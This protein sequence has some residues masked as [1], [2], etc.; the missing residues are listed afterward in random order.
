MV[1]IILKKRN[2]HALSEEEIQFAVNGF[3][4][5]SIP[6]YQMS[7]FLMAIYFQK[8]DDVE[9]AYLT[10]AMLRSGE[11]MDLSGIAGHVIDK[12]STGGVGDKTS[13][14]LAPLVAATGVPI[15][16]MSGRGLGHTGGT[17]DKLEAISGFNIDLE[18]SNF[19]KQVQDI[20][21][22]MCGQ[23]PNLVPADK[24]IYALRDVT[25]TVDNVSLIASSIM[26][27]KLAS[28]AEGIVIDIK[29]G[30]GAFMK[31][32]EDGVELARI[33]K[34]IA[35]HM[36]K[37]FTAI[38]TSMQQPLGNAIG[39][40][41]EVKEAIAT[42]RG[43]GPSDLLDVCLTLG[44]EMM[45]LS[46]VVDN[47]D[48]AKQ[49][50]SEKINSGAAFSKFKEWIA[51]QGGDVAQVEDMRLLPSCKFT[52]AY[53]AKSS[54]YIHH[55][56]ASNLGLASMKLGAGREHKDSVLNYGAG[57][58]LHH[59]VGDY[60]LEADTICTLYADDDLLF[61]LAEVYLNEAFD[62]KADIPE[63]EKMILKLI[64]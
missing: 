1:D 18:I 41:L 43:E 34:S 15:A 7:A 54:G 52:K 45:L 56:M 21:I 14:I 10:N 55:I 60:V 25:A 64:K 53:T 28:G 20:G 29:I 24:K 59:K 11:I 49:I 31:S 46:G 39:N 36:G 17:L 5:G 19:I 37:K 48:T 44:A 30:D 47:K 2:G 61:S 58:Y 42:L 57:I 63:I 51:A 13:L 62:I 50:L 9:T 38:L 8:L 40:A 33:M 6:D 16:K 26:S 3:V 12:H 22:A 4:K 23:T 27:K 32:V 35:T